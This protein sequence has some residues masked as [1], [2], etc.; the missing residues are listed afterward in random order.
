VPGA[1]QTLDRGSC[2]VLADARDDQRGGGGAGAVIGPG[3]EGDAVQQCQQVCFEGSAE[4]AGRNAGVEDAL[5][6]AAG[7][8][9]GDRVAGGGEEFA[10]PIGPQIP[11]GEGDEG[12]VAIADRPQGEDEARQGTR[13]VGGRRFPDGDSEAYRFPRVR[14]E[15]LDERG[16]AGEV[17][18][19]GSTCDA[20]GFGDVG[21]AAV[22]VAAQFLPGRLQD[23]F[24]GGTRRAA[25]WHV[26]VWPVRH[27]STSGGEWARG[28]RDICT[29]L[30]NK[31]AYSS[32]CN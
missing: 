26:R 20:R 31:L 13:R 27:V 4:G 9:P 6:L 10:H 30:G 29:S 11:A 7:E 24:A 25:P 16:P 3:P 12:A 14:G 8:D 19:D 22:G 21:E 15:S 28:L 17:D 2:V 23:A 1:V 5:P 18:V 32:M